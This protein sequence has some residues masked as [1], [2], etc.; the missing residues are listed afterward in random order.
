MLER[1]IIKAVL[2][3]IGCGDQMTKMQIALIGQK[4]GIDKLSLTKRGS[5]AIIIPALCNYIDLKMTGEVK[6]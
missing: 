2:D 4:W 6:E 5:L 1:R 3:L